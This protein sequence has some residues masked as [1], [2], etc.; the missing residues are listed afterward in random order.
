MAAREKKQRDLQNAGI[1]QEQALTEPGVGYARRAEAKK[2][3]QLV[4][5]DP[6][7]AKALLG[8][9]IAQ[10]RATAMAL[11]DEAR[12]KL[13]DALA[14]GAYSDAE[15]ADVSVATRNAVTATDD[16]LRKQE[17]LDTLV[18]KPGSLLEGADVT[19]TFNAVA[20]FGMGLGTNAQ[21]RTASA[22]EETAK[23]TKRVADAAE[24]GLAFTP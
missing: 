12:R 15:R 18:N 8:R 23:N 17:E 11:A 6:E 20:A 10:A 2:M 3:E 21:E 1:E 5:E 22:S 14:D 13:R 24:K 19:Q 16:W 9:Q 4:R 7:Q